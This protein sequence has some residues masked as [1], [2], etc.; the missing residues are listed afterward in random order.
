MARQITCSYCG[1]KKWVESH[2]YREI[3]AKFRVLTKAEVNQ[4]YLCRP[5]RHARQP[6]SLKRTPEF[7]RLQ[8]ALQETI[9]EYVRRGWNNLEAEKFCKNNV[10]AIL[11]SHHIEPNEFKVIRNGHKINGIV[12]LNIPFWHEVLVELYWKENKN[13]W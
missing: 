3:R 2:N 8:N 4:K 10:E 1:L 13:E 6:N 11:K 7:K 12:L 9:D 5:C